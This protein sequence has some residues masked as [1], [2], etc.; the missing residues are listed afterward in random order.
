MFRAVL[1]PDENTL[2]TAIADRTV[3]LRDISDPRSPQ[4]VAESAGH[5][6]TVGTPVLS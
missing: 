1:T 3:R 6:A 5:S 4:R 2:A